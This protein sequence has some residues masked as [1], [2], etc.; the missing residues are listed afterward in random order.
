MIV[1]VSL[2][3]VRAKVAEVLAPLTLATT[4]YG[5]PPVA[6]AV[7]VKLVSPL[8]PVTGI[9]EKVADAPVVGALAVTVAPETALPCASSTR[10]TSGAAKASFTVA[11]CGVPEITVTLA[12]V[13]AVKSTVTVP[14]V[15]LP[16]VAVKESDSAVLSIPPK[17]V[18]PL[19]LVEAGEPVTVAV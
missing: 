3:L 5:P 2:L 10:T 19:E 6:L 13:P 7:A 11:L 4:L 12:G 17:V 1:C 15:V 14:M 8:L 18:T 16:L 9:V